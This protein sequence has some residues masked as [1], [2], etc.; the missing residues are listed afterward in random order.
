MSKE[1]REKLPVSG[2]LQ[3]KKEPLGLHSFRPE[4][5][6]K[7]IVTGTEGDVSN[8]DRFSIVTEKVD[9]IPGE[10]NWG[11]K[12]WAAPDNNKMPCDPHN[13]LNV[14]GGFRKE[15]LT[16]YPDGRTEVI[17]ATEVAWVKEPENGQRYTYVKGYTGWEAI[18]CR[19]R[20]VVDGEQ[21]FVRDREEEIK[22]QKYGLPKDE[23]PPTEA[24]LP[25]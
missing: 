24:G 19:K 20:R 2:A 10:R 8:S 21:T 11:D 7:A 17:D 18:V 22:I 9:L 13:V 12:S 6:P 15:S 14:V 23:A 3:K 25:G 5:Q 1:N 4:W 16:V